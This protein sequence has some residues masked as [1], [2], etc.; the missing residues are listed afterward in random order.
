MSFK[1]Y[2]DA[3]N[4]EGWPFMPGQF[5]ENCNDHN[6]LRL[7][8]AARFLR[9]RVPQHGFPTMHPSDKKF[10]RCP[11]L[12]ADCFGGRTLTDESDDSWCFDLMIRCGD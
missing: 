6:E 2:S 7:V 1:T 4:Q 5:S 10:N 3:R 11:A 12:S 9:A 8:T